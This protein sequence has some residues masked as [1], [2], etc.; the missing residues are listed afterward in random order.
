[1]A[2]V[3]IAEDSPTQAQQLQFLLEDAGHQ[4]V[5]VQ[6]GREALAAMARQ[7]VDIVVTDL[8]MPEINGLELVEA[9]RIHYPRVPVVLMTAFGSEEIAALALQ[10]GASSY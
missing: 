5:A 6:N 10:K 3:L 9:V 4:V 2:K 8:E 1:M 7:L